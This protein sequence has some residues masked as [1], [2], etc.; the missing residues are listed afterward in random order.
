MNGEIS[1]GGPNMFI[2]SQSRR[3]AK[4]SFALSRPSRSVSLFTASIFALCLISIS[5]NFAQASLGDT[6]SSDTSVTNEKA[7]LNSSSHQLQT[8][9]NYN[10]HILT[11]GLATV[12]EYT[13]KDG[14]VFAVTWKGTAKP[15]LEALFGTYYAEYTAANSARGKVQG[16]AP[17]AFKTANLAVRRG[18]HMRALHG[19][20]VLTSLVPSGVNAE[21]LP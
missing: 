12:R 21:A 1:A 18:G 13:T 4:F 19:S 6:L 5:S 14:V 2:E 7:K 11:S 9:T 3:V 16:H 8:T 20:A 17:V 10:V 15:D